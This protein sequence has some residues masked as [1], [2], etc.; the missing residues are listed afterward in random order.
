MFPYFLS[1]LSKSSS[2]SLLFL[3]R[4][5]LPSRLG[6]PVLPQN[7]ERFLSFHTLRRNWSVTLVQCDNVYL[8]RNVWDHLSGF[9]TFCRMT[10]FLCE[11]TSLKLNMG[12]FVFLLWVGFKAPAR[13]A[14]KRYSSAARRHIVHLAT[15]KN[16][17]PQTQVGP[18]WGCKCVLFL[19]IVTIR[20]KTYVQQYNIM[21]IF[22][23]NFQKHCAR[24]SEA[25]RRPETTTNSP[26][27]GPAESQ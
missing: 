13:R 4:F 3:S 1:V 20:Y 14:P 17:L 21:V 2:L 7:L 24:R 12:N 6:Y 5:A 9:C 8:K 27:T 10:C 23:I 18:C 15:R 22:L 25:A 19:Y 16:I 11:R 26:V